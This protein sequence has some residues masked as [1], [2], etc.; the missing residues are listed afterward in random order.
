MSNQEQEAKLQNYDSSEK[1]KI[2][3]NYNKFHKLYTLKNLK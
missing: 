2:K 3:I 1:F